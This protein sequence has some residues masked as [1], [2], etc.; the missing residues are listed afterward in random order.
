MKFWF[1]NPHLCT[2]YINTY[3]YPE[4]LNIFLPAFVFPTFK[5]KNK[6]EIKEKLSRDY[7]ILLLQGV[8]S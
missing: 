7:N 1:S 8:W 2:S 3:F 6:W 4:I 5:L